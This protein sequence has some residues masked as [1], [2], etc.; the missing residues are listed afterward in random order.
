MSE[1]SSIAA[2]GDQ[3]TVFAFKA[4]GV[5]A[6]AVANEAEGREKLR[7]L[8]RNYDII[9]I[10]EQL[11]EA[12]PD[13]LARYKTRAFPAVIPVPSSK[14]STGYGKRSIKADVEKAIGTDIL[15]IEENGND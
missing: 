15:Q 8:A 1:R 7:L 2:L 5:D 4:V 12:L 9:F 10:T 11:A 14:G 13:L 6:Y 3:D